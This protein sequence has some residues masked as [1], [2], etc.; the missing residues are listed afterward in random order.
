MFLLPKSSEPSISGVVIL[1]Q[2]TAWIYLVP[3]A[4]LAYLSDSLSRF[5]GT[6]RGSLYAKMYV[7]S[8]KILVASVI[9]TSPIILPKTTDTEN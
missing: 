5:F 2:E 1:D 6:Q 3:S 9:T 4:N 8:I 7:P